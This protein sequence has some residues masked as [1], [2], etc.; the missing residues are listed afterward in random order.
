M[1]ALLCLVLGAGYANRGN[2]QPLNVRREIE[3]G[4]SEQAVELLSQAIEATEENATLFYWRG[5]EQFRLG[6]IAESLADFNHYYEQLPA[7]QSR[8]WERGI[9]CYY[10]GKF[11]E[12]S[13]QFR[14][15]QTYHGN[16][17][18]NAVWKAMCDARLE[19]FEKASKEILPIESDRRAPM[20]Q[21][22]EMFKG[23]MTPEQVIQIAKETS[24]ATETHAPSFYAQLYVGLYYEAN[25]KPELAKKHIEEATKLKIDHYMWDVAQVHW[26]RMK[27]D[28]NT[29]ERKRSP[30]QESVQPQQPTAK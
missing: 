27:S 28:A 13:D 2:A 9:T 26:Q 16:D 30:Y 24:D 1:F 7:T 8:Q 3:K 23:Q 17:V 21:I 4:N 25:D 6:K 15:Y 5:R 20:M 19:G 14:L 29:Q 10:A 18:E 22:Y 12:G 11:K